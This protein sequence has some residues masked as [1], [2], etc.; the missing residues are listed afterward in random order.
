[1]SEVTANEIL[2]DITKVN[3]DAMRVGFKDVRAG[4]WVFDAMG[5]R[6]KLARVRILKN[7]TLSIKRDDYPFTEHIVTPDCT[8]TIVPAHGWSDT[9]TQY[10]VWTEDGQQCGAFYETCRCGLILEDGPGDDGSGARTLLRE[11]ANQSNG[12]GEWY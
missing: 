2:T 8:I 4:D 10:R 1:M 3:W 11:H 12:R 7:G 5:G 6:H 9:P